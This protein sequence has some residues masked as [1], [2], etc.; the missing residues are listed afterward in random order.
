MAQ[1][2]R[3]E[4]EIDGNKYILK[5][6]KSKDD[7]IGLVDFVQQRIDEATNAGNRYN[8]LM[9]HSLALMNIADDY[10]ELK[11][12]L[13]EAERDLALSKADAEELRPSKKELEENYK[14]LKKEADNFSLQ[15][16]KTRADLSEAKARLKLLENKSRGSDRR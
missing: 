9:R 1:V 11:K 7:V 14:K 8:K 6:G 2:N 4:I 3:I 12:S 15:V 16:S 10:F 5:T 13:K